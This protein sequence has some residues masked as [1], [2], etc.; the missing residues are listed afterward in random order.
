MPNYTTRQVADLLGVSDSRVRQL[1]IRHKVGTHFGRALM[2]TAR[3][4]E[5]LRA[6]R[7]AP[8]RPKKPATA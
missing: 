3:D 5:K 8:G 1:A 6:A 7:L 2:F 4:V